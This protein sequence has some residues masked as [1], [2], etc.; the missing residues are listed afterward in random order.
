MLRDRTR[1]PEAKAK[2]LT[3]RAE[4]ARKDAARLAW[5]LFA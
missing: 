5:L 4:R 1:R 2:R 3:R